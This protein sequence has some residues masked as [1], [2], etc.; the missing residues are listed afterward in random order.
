ML[1]MRCIALFM[2]LSLLIAQSRADDAS[3]IK[4]GTTQPST[5]PTVDQDTQIRQW[6]RDLVAADGAT[7]QQARVNLMS[8]DPTRLPELRR[9]CLAASP[10]TSAQIEAL[11]DV[12]AQ[13]YLQSQ[14]ENERVN[15]MLVEDQREREDLGFVGVRMGFGFSDN[16]V[17]GVYAAGIVVYRRIPGFVGY[18]VLQ[19]GDVIRGIKE[20]PGIKMTQIQSFVDTVKALRTGSVIH[21]QI[22]RAGRELTIPIRLDPRPWWA[23]KTDATLDPDDDPINQE[24]LGKAFDYWVTQFAVGIDPELT[25]AVSQ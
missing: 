17:N 15:P 20:A 16:R 11:K 12:V 19:D 18:R 14:L 4:P 13:L 6:L 21:L 1:F 5:Q 23:N 9:V 24:R 2:M 22:L 3:T 25:T 8:I 7:R 10:L